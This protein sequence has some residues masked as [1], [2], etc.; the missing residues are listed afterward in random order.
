MF[1][2]RVISELPIMRQTRQDPKMSVF[3]F[4]DRSTVFCCILVLIEL[5]L[6]QEG[7]GGAYPCSPMLSVRKQCSGKWEHCVFSVFVSQ[8]SLTLILLMWRIGLVPNSIP[9]YVYIQQDA[10]LHSL[11][12][13]GNCSTCFGVVLPP[14]IRSAYNCI[15]SIWYLSHRYCY[16]PLSWKSWNIF[17]WAVGGVRHPQHTQFILLLT[18][19]AG[20]VVSGSEQCCYRTFDLNKDTAPI[21]VDSY[22]VVT[23]A[24]L[25]AGHF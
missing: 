15:Y 17:E 3:D 22:I 25:Q 20:C 2:D 18:E 16:L 11:F 19:S 7:G 13:S 1:A 8:C 24:A 6:I 12:I 5:R 21:S 4:P 9:I 23:P 10:K 14:I